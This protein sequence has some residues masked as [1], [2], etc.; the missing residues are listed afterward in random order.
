MFPIL[1]RCIYDMLE[2]ENFN[3]NTVRLYFLILSFS[4]FYDMD[5]LRV[6]C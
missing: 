3:R 1:K 4:L 5:L 2:R 6:D